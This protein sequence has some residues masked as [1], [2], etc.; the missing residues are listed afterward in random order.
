[1]A[2]LE[3]LRLVLCKLRY[4]CARFTSGEANV[5]MITYWGCVIRHIS[6]ELD[7]RCKVLAAPLCL[8][9]STNLEMNKD[10]RF[11]L[12]LIEPQYTQILLYLPK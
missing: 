6:S 10:G 12:S 11:A 2:L 5:P 1:M 3:Q 7:L 9:C 8:G 4:P